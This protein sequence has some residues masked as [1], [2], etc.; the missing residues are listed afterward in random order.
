MLKGLPDNLCPV[1]TGGL[2]QGRIQF[3][4][5]SGDA[6]VAESGNGFY[7]A[8]GHTALALEDTEVMVLSPAGQLKEV[9]DHVAKVMGASFRLSRLPIG[10]LV[11]A[12][13]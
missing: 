2:F 5:K 6:I 10:C 13:F 11:V 12:P 9:A 4:G 1:R 7:L 3:R 8:P